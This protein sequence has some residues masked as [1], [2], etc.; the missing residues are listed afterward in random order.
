[1]YRSFKSFSLIALLLLAGLASKANSLKPA[2]DTKKI[3][4]YSSNESVPTVII[5]KNG[6]IIKVIYSVLDHIQ[7]NAKAEAQMRADLA[8][9]M[10]KR[11]TTKIEP[12][13]DILMEKYKEKNYIYKKDSITLDAKTNANYFALV[14]KVFAADNKT[15]D[16]G[17]TRTNTIMVDGMTFNFKI[18]TSTGVRTL[19]AWAPNA[20]THP[21]LYSLIHGSYDVY[22][23]KKHNNFL[24]G[25][26]IG[27]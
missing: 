24:T 11:N 6:S 22:H 2:N 15:L 21:L 14:D 19:A 10:Q 20:T 5:V 25:K 27:Y 16:N 17:M 3:V 13:V 18:I 9:L 7:R 1:M 4:I 23:A 12:A 26:T 8:A